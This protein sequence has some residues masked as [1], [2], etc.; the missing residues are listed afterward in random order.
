[1]YRSSLFGFFRLML[2][3][4]AV[5][6]PLQPAAQAQLAVFDPTNLTQNALSAARALEQVRNQVLQITNQIRQLENDARNLTSLG[7]TFA[8][9]LMSQLDQLDQL[10][11]AARGLALKVNET[12]AAL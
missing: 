4:V 2:A 11:N 10:I 1:M 8:P 5:I 6:S 7:R 9:E 12:R 3:S